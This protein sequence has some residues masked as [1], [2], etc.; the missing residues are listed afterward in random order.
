MY[1]LSDEQFEK[2]KKEYKENKIE[3]SVQLNLARK[4]LTEAGDIITILWGCSFTL[5]LVG[6]LFF[7]ISILGIWGI[8]YAILFDIFFMSYMG[9]C[10]LNGTIKE[11]VFWGSIFTMLILYFFKFSINPL[12]IASC[13]SFVSVYLFYFYVG[14]KTVHKIGLADK[15]NFIFLIENNI[16]IYK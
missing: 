8:L 16:I 2:I 11:V 10:S 9:L 4:F 3:I 5:I 7:S 14:Y 15:E 13:I 6:S 12:L 1:E